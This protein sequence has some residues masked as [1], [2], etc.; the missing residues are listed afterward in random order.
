LPLFGSDMTNE[1]RCFEITTRRR[2]GIDD[3]AAKHGVL[4]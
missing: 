2:A 1:I 3:V 4:D